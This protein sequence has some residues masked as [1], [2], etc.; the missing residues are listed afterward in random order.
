MTFS[1]LMDLAGNAFCGGSLLPALTAMLTCFPVVE[2]INA[3]RG[4]FQ[5]DDKENEEA[6]MDDAGDG[7]D[8][9]EDDDDGEDN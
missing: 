7:N 5:L 3:L 9:D 8:G 6:I 4:A 2:D 1:N